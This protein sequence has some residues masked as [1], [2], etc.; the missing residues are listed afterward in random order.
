LVYKKSDAATKEKT[1][2]WIFARKTV[3]EN[4]P[5]SLK[6][7]RIK[8]ELQQVHSPNLY[9][10]SMLPERFWGVTKKTRGRF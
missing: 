5:T 6:L 4:C 7:Q 2:V 8:G 9:N 1:T 3:L 10:P